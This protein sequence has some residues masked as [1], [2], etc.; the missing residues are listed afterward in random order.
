MAFNPGDM[1]GQYRIEAQLGYGGMATI[2]KAHHARLARSV[3]IKVLHPAFVQDRNFLARFQREAQIVAGLEHRHIVPI[4]D[5][6]EIDGQPYLVL[7]YIEG[8]TLK[9]IVE[10][11]ALP[12]SEILRIMTPI[13]DALDYAHGQGVLHRDIKP[14][15]ILIERDG[16]PYLTDFGL[17]RMA[18]IG[19]ST[20][21]TDVLL[22]TPNYISPEQALGR[23]DID[24][25]ADVYALGV[26]LYELVTGRVPFSADTPY[27]VIHDHIYSEL[28]KPSAINPQIPPAVE[29]VL[30][31]A[32][33]KAP[34]E[35]YES[36]GTL[37]AAFRDAITS[38]GLE[39]REPL[40]KAASPPITRSQLFRDD[41][42]TTPFPTPQPVSAAPPLS[43]KSK[44][45]R[46]V[47]ASLDFNFEN[48]GRTLGNLGSQIRDVVEDSIDR[49]EGK[50]LDLAPPDDYRA[51]RS[52]AERSVKNR[53]EFFGHLASFV[54][55]NLFLWALFLF[56]LAPG[57]GFPW[58]F[59][60][61]FG[62]GAG[63]AAHAIETYAQTGARGIERTRRIH[64]GL[65][66]RYGDGWWET[67]SRAELRRAR[68]QIDK[69]YHD[70][71][72]LG[73]HI[74]VYV[75]IN[76]MLW[77]IFL[78]AGPFIAVD[79]P[80]LMEILRFPWPMFVTIGW[81]IGLAADAAEKLSSRRNERAIEREMEAE[82][83]QLYGEKAKRD[84]YYDDDDDDYSSDDQ[85]DVRLTG[86]GE[87]TD[88]MIDEIERQQRLKRR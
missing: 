79:E 81:G 67:V 78:S 86:D 4:Y 49:L 77:L 75:M 11:G 12:L 60:V 22:G 29:A 18:Q 34:E 53:S 3:A 83:R 61:T 76:V 46:E 23:K 66:E 70:R 10:R 48:I 68:N 27:A 2:Y 15:N 6:D 69:P 21:S 31:K 84:S 42:P 35:R 64:E 40:V 9:A 55:V 56:V 73:Q 65:R 82:R 8:E 32:L 33:A 37:V 39:Q 45:H 59:F 54:A 17:A 36:A 20:L 19:D 80:G 52:R 38:S 5:F 74:V 16:T 30:V 88:S 62:W 63:L 28:P 51:A 7:K 47:E 44:R 24:A 50:D 71:V 72:E 57:G 43:E 25:R 14:S 87:L 1:I 13:A 41:Q 26:V 85:L 58:P